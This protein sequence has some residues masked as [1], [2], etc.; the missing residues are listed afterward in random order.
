[1]NEFSWNY[2][3]RTLWIR[4]LFYLWAFQPFPILP[5]KQ[6][7]PGGTAAGIQQDQPLTSH[8]FPPRGQ[9]GFWH[10]DFCSLRQEELP[11][12]LPIP[13]YSHRDGAGSPGKRHWRVQGWGRGGRRKKKCAEEM[14][15]LLQA[16]LPDLIPILLFPRR[17]KQWQGK[18]GGRISFRCIQEPSPVKSAGYIRDFRQ[19]TWNQ[20]P[21]AT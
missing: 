5:G 19:M 3:A 4:D 9:A 2:T 16:R 11:C 12:S 20:H 18:G 17:K 6:P 10:R 13:G 8:Q 21:N 14:N 15:Q 1:M 7:A